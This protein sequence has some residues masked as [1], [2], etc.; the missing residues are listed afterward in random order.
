VSE[1]DAPRPAPA[2]LAGSRKLAVIIAA[3]LAPPLLI[4][5][6]YIAI[7][8]NQQATQAVWDA[9]PAAA[10]A[11]QADADPAVLAAGEAIYRQY[12]MNC[13]GDGGASGPVGPQLLDTAWRRDA[14]YPALFKAI[15][16]GKPKTP[17]IAWRTTLVPDQVH[18]VASYVWSLAPASTPVDDDLMETGARP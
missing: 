7:R 12:C 4:G 9:T 14:D 1:E 5:A 3:A 15:A 11:Q 16:D 8:N 10:Q 2:Q 6:L 13:H 17:M 18:A